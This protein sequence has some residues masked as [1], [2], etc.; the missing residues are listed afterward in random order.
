MTAFEEIGEKMKA[1]CLLHF[2]RTEDLRIADLHVIFPEREKKTIANDIG[3]KK[4]RVAKKRGKFPL[5]TWKEI[6]LY[7]MKLTGNGN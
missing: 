4:L 2:G 1:L 3:K 6:T 5:F 7:E